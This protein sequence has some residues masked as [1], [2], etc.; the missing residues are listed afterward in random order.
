MH[1]YCKIQLWKV[2]RPG[3]SLFC[4]LTKLLI[5]YIGNIQKL[6][7]FRIFLIEE[8]IPEMRK[9]W[10]ENGNRAGEN[11][12]LYWGTAIVSYRLQRWSGGTGETWEHEER[13]NT[14]RGW[15]TG[16]EMKGQLK[17]ARTKGDE[18]DQNFRMECRV[19]CIFD[20]E[21]TR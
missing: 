2:S 9:M 17:D 8:N 20:T 4:I 16:K 1:T 12:M 15:E 18:R 3:C 5:I 10:N 13:G 11:N 7:G 14:G 21:E 19:H 6:L